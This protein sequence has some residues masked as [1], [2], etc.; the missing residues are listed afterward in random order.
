MSKL[1]RPR[2]GAVDKL[3]LFLFFAVLSAGVWGVEILTGETMWAF[4]GMT[5]VVV[6]TVALVITRMVFRGN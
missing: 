6:L 1:R 2:L 5:V 4:I 3:L